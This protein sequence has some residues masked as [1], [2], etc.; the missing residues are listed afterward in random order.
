MQHVLEPQRGRAWVES[1]YLRSLIAGGLAGTTVDL[2][3]FPLDTLKTR[4]QSSS[5]FASA[6]GF[7]GIYRGVGSALIGSAPGAALFFITY[8]SVKRHLSPVTPTIAHNA[9]GKPYVEGGAG[10]SGGRGREAGVHMLAASLGEVAACAV[11]VPTEVVKQRAQARQHPSSASA[12]MYILNQRHTHG[13]VHVWRELYRG[14]SITLLREV[15]FTVIQFPLWEALKRWRVHDSGRSEVTGLEGGLLGSVA[16]AVAAGITTPLDVLKTR[17]ML[18]KEKQP[19]LSMLR[20]ILQQSGP[21]AF[22]AGI[23]PRVGW[24]SVGGAI[25]LGS[26]QWAS[27]AMGRLEEP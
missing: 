21:R 8:D 16:G 23:G 6:G 14:W 10:L 13:F 11:R 27:N 1:P 20:E 26:Y 7:T 24:I 3:L 12:L 18:A 19:M 4:L 25:F 9:E 17:M 15:P 2:S 22:F 5:G